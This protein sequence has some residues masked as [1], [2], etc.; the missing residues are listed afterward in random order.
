MPMRLRRHDDGLS[1]GQD[2]RAWRRI[3]V[4]GAQMLLILKFAA[5]QAL[6]VRG[7]DPSAFFGD[8]D[9]YDF[10]FRFVNGVENRCG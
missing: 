2:G 1:L 10:V 4:A 9:R 6:R 7:R 8:A 3:G 5:Q